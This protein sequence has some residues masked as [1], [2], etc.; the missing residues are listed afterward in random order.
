MTEHI[1]IG[2]AVTCPTVRM[3][4]AIIAQ[5]AATAALMSSGRFDL[6]IGSGENLN[7]HITGAKWPAPRIRLE[8]LEEAI[9]V[10]FQLWKGGDQNFYGKHYQVENA[11]IFSLPQQRH[12]LLMAAA[13][14]CAAKLAGRLADGLIATSPEPSLVKEFER[15]GGANKPRYG[16]MTMCWAPSRDEALRTAREIWPNALVRGEVSA[17]LALPRHFEQITE[18][19]SAD[20]MEPVGGDTCGPSVEIHVAA[21]QEFVDAGFDH[22]YLHQVGDNQLAFLEFAQSEICRDL[23]DRESGS[24]KAGASSLTVRYERNASI[25]FN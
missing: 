16:Q 15:G 11:R 12:S 17:E 25:N 3:H 10:I 14:K 6:G 13:K 8:M 21:I 5:A 23:H 1:R 22:V 2:T 7:E 4:L 20:L 9:N 18:D 24:Q 19:L